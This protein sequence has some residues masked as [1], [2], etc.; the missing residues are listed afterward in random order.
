MR[1]K[2]SL[3]VQLNDVVVGFELGIVEGGDFAQIGRLPSGGRSEGINSGPKQISVVVW[4]AAREERQNRDQTGDQRHAAAVGRT[5]GFV[6]VERGI[7]ATG[8]QTVHRPSR[9]DRRGAGGAGWV[10]PCD[11][12]WRR[13]TR[14]QLLPGPGAVIVLSKMFPKKID[15]QAV[16]R[17]PQS[18]HSGR[19]QVPSVDV[20]IRHG[21]DVETIALRHGAGKAKGECLSERNVDEALDPTGI[22]I[23]EF[24]LQLSRE[25]TSFRQ[26]R[27]HVDHACSGV[28]SVQGALRTAQ[29]LKPLDVE[30]L[31]LKEP[32][33]QQGGV[34]E[35]DRHSRIRRDRHGLGADA[36]DRKV[37][38]C[39]IVLREGYVG[40]GAQQLGPALDFTVVQLLGREGRDRDRNIDDP[41]LNAARG[42]DHLFEVCGSRIA[43]KRLDRCGR[44]SRVGALSRPDRR[45]SGCTAYDHG[46]FADELVLDVQPI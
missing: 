7:P 39:E 38:T 5:I 18:A 35:A 20:L 6:R 26:V 42:H 31:L 3:D 37:V 14:A 12:R 43:G 8:R 27:Q 9:K 11:A 36:T 16:V 23:A 22:V 25:L 45:G 1:C 33:S 24:T 46:A 30:I 29:H 4:P 28:S 10:G 34:V 13:A 15:A 40:N 41:F 21:V 2:L 44:R 32:V 17:R 19:P